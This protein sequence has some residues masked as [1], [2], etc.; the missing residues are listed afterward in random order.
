MRPT[1]QEPATSD[2]DL[3]KIVTTKFAESSG[4]ATLVKN[5]QWTEEDRTRRPL[6]R[7]GRM[8]DDEGSKVHRRA[9]A[10]SPSGWPPGPRT[11]RSHCCSTGVRRQTRGPQLL[12]RRGD[13]HELLHIT[14]K[15]HNPLQSTHLEG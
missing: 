12:T 3:E 15:F 4:P 13:F 1:R 11:R 10:A 7:D 5:F 2:Y 9:P 6:D 8:S 14:I